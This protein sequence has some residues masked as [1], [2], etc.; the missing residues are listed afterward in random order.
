LKGGDPFIF[1]RGGEE[2]EELAAS[3]IPFEVVPGI[4]SAVAVP[5][6]AGIPLTHRR[7][8]SA[9]GFIT[10]HEEAD[11]QDSQIAWEK[12]ATGLG[13]LVFLMGH[14]QLKS[15]TDRLI[16]EGRDPNTPVALIQWGTLPGQKTVVGTLSDIGQRAEEAHMSPP[17]IIVV[18]EVVGLRSILNWFE[19]RPLFGKRVLV[20]RAREQASALME[21]LEAEGAEAI[22]L[23]VIQIQPPADYWELDRAVAEIE[24]FDWVIFTSVHGVEFFW[25]RLK[26]GGK[27]ARALKGIRV[28]AIGPATASKLREHGLEPDL[29]PPEY[30]AEAILEAMS[31]E[32]VRGKRILLP[33]ADKARDLLPKA[34]E[35]RG[36]KVIVVEAYRTAKP[37]ADFEGIRERLRQGEIEVITFTSSST[38]VHF[39]EGIGR[40]EIDSLEKP[41]AIACIG[42]VTAGS[43]QAHGLKV[44][45]Q[46]EEYT[47]PSLVRAIRSYFEK[48]ED[49]P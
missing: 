29:V 40:S 18:G 34:L 41:V 10:G 47:I 14:G 25:Q 16:R 46:P 49:R 36:A 30:R 9:V 8:A 15:I 2:A 32:E 20:T 38:V 6:Y 33:R 24:D 27:D 23:P 17:V 11:R 19:D 7:Y 31:G 3:G 35:E 26:E 37:E 45:I 44:D 48:G 5:A 12:I 43:A 21:L 22:S 4:S 13:T 28:G 1:G 42:P 39:L